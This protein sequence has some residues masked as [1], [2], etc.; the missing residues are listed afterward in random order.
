VRWYQFRAKNTLDASCPSSDFLHLCSA[1]TLRSSIA[2]T[3]TMSSFLD[4]LFGSDAPA[5]SNAPGSSA[6]VAPRNRNFRSSSRP[7][8]PPS[9]SAGAN[10]DIEGFEDDE[11]VGRR[12]NVQRPR[13][14]PGDI[15][16][17]VDSIGE[18]LVNEFENFL[19]KYTPNTSRIRAFANGMIATWRILLLQ[20]LLP[21]ALLA[22]HDTM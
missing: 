18:A 15:P 19:E 20:A 1:Q 10:S 16:K 9:E 21:L 12:G 4:G 22:T 2:N 14:P 5:S 11:I 7:R 6:S 8:G 17:V 3:A 13:G